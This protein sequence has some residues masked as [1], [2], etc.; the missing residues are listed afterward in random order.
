MYFPNMEKSS[1]ISQKEQ[2]N[3][4]FFLQAEAFAWIRG[5]LQPTQQKNPAPLCPVQARGAE[6]LSLK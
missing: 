4:R 2:K 6:A 3:E 5:S 1:G